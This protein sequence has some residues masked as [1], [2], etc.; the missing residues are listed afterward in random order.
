MPVGMNLID[1]LTV[2]DRSEPEPVKKI[3]TAE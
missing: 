1:R 2:T 3:T